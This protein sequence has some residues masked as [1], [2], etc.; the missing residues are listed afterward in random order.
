MSM[1]TRTRIPGF[2]FLTRPAVA[3]AIII[4]KHWAALLL[5]DEAW[6]RDTICSKK[7]RSTFEEKQIPLRDEL[8]RHQSWQGKSRDAAL[9]QFSNQAIMMSFND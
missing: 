4:G 2:G 3:L 9:P 8:R 1:S 7:D 6:T 5:H